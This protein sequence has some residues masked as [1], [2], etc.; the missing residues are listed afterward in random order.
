MCS[1]G[2]T[3]TTAR[4]LEHGGP[5]RDPGEVARGQPRPPAPSSLGLDPHLRRVAHAA[6]IGAFFDRS[7]RD[8]AREMSISQSHHSWARRPGSGTCRRPRAGLRR[9]AAIAG[10]RGHVRLRG[11]GRTRGY[12]PREAAIVGADRLGRRRGCLELTLS[13]SNASPRRRGQAEP[14]DAGVVFAGGGAAARTGLGSWGRGQLL[15]ALPHLVRRADGHRGCDLRAPRATTGRATGRPIL[16]PSGRGPRVRGSST[17]ARGSLA[18]LL[19]R[20]DLESSP[21]LR[22]R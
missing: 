5:R 4:P 16:A 6:C 10:R 1:G 13:S 7:R 17:R 3:T 18:P 14:H 19:S 2:S 9:S 20:P 8:I 15:P 21:I 11:R 22:A 12:A